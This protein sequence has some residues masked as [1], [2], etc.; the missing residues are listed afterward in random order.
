MKNLLIFDS[1]PPGYRFSS[2]DVEVITLLPKED[3]SSA[4]TIENIIEVN[5]Y[6]HHLKKLTGSLFLSIYS[7]LLYF[8]YSDL[9]LGQIQVSWSGSVLECFQ[10]GL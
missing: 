7:T 4:S 6:A 8:D 5:L 1:L 3:S 9:I 2:T 10:L